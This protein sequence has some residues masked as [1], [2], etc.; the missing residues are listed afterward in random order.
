MRIDP[1]VS[2]YVRRYLERVHGSTMFRDAVGATDEELMDPDNVPD[3][4]AFLQA[5]A[6]GN[7]AKAQ[8]I[9]HQNPG[10]IK[11]MAYLGLL[12][13]NHW[14]HE[15]VAEWTMSIRPLVDVA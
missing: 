3:G 9:Y 8:Y 15:E 1:Y 10:S 5:C 13:A 11:N 14:E 2:A 4:W 7:C 12:C 6:N